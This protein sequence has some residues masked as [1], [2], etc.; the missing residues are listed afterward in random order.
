MKIEQIKSFD[1]HKM[2]LFFND[3]KLS[4]RGFI[5]IHSIF[6]KLSLGATR[7]CEY[8][9]E[10]DALNDV[11]KLSKNMTY[12]CAV[13]DIKYGGAK[14][15][16]I[17]KEKSYKSIDFLKKYAFFVNSLNGL[18]KTGADVGIFEEDIKIL[19][20][21]SKH[22]IDDYSKNDPSY[23]TAVGI[24]YAIKSSL[25]FVFKNDLFID[26]TFAIKGV[27]KVGFNL[28]KLILEHKGNVIV[29]DKNDNLIKK[30]KKTFPT[31]KIVDH[32][33]IHKEKVDVYSPCA[34]SNEFTEKNIKDL[35]CKIICGGANNQL[36]NE[37]IG[38]LIFKKGIIYVPDYLSNSGGLISVVSTYENKSKKFL[39]NKIKKIY[40]KVYNL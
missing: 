4:L 22:I 2:V 12:K 40:N 19:K 17:K 23:W 26:K 31:V 24:F 32:K 33:N 39:L 20:K 27:G 3:D 30:I 16:I 13:S 36:E 34:L 1:N 21:Y 29:S 7:F 14:A 15:V 10:I 8:K 11:L 28:L 18:F 37:V 38:E 35:N 25:N 6:N 5:A 9:S